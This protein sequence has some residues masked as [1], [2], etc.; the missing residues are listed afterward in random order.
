MK[1]KLTEANLKEVIKIE[2][3]RDV[4]DDLKLTPSQQ[5]DVVERLAV[6]EVKEREARSL[7]RQAKVIGEYCDNANRDSG[8]IASSKS[9][10]IMK[11]ARQKALSEIFDVLL[12]TVEYYCQN[13]NPS[14]EQQ[15]SQ[16]SVKITPETFIQFVQQ[17]NAP[18][19]VENLK[20]VSISS[21]L[22]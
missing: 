6:R 14:S 12:I 15:A 22:V 8:S 18:I 10:R 20:R 11:F 9:D 7:T 16:N 5:Q 13:K 1:N 19:V 4:S 17:Q 21:P 2:K 3:G